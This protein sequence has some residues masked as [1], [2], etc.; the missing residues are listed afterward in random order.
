M[1]RQLVTMICSALLLLSWF[2]SDGTAA[3]ILDPLLNPLRDYLVTPLVQERTVSLPPAFILTA[4]LFMGVLLG[5]MGIVLA[6]PL[7]AV[8]LVLVK[9]LYI[10][11][12]LGEGK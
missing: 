10:E 4:Q 5:G 8:V 3:S 1:K 9:M 11:D 12:L 6:V 2:V 7:F